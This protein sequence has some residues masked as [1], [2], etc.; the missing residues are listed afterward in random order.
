MESSSFLRLLYGVAL[1][2]KAMSVLKRLIKYC[3]ASSEIGIKNTKLSSVYF[4]YQLAFL[5][6]NIRDFTKGERWEVVL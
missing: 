6:D 3:R 5:S 4:E 1:D 2:C